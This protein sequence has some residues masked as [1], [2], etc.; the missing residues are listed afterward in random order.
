M[1]RL[2]LCF[3]AVVVM[4]ILYY[5]FSERLQDWRPLGYG[6]AGLYWALLLFGCAL[7]T[8]AAKKLRSA[9]ILAIILLL[10]LGSR[11]CYI[12]LIPTQPVSDFALL[13]ESAQAAAAGDF[14]WSQATSGYFYLWA[15]QIPFVLYEAGVLRLFHSLFALKF[16]NVLFM[17]GSNY[18]LYRIAKSFLSETAALCATL[19]YAAFPGAIMFASV[20]TNQHISLFFLL[21]GVFFLLQAESW[22]TLLLSGL[23]LAVS[24]LMRPEAIV[25]FAAMG[26]CGLL[27][28]IQH[29]TRKS[30]VSFFA[31]F[32]IVF[33]FYWVAQKLVEL[34]L[35]GM[36]VAPNGLANH[37]P[38]WKFVLGLGNVNGYGS[39]SGENIAI[40]SI[41]DSAAR[42]NAVI[43]VIRNAFAHSQISLKD[44]FLEKANR[45]WT[46]PQSMNWSTWN[47]ADN[48]QVLPGLT[49]EGF[50]AYM[51]WFE[52]AALLLV[53]LLALPAPVFL[54]RK[55][56]NKKG[57]ALFCLA[58][59]FI[60]FCVYLL[61]ETQI[62]Y[63]YFAIP[64]WILAGGI[65][66]EWLTGSQEKKE[67]TVK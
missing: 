2:A 16:L 37:A 40:L 67:R 56:N 58:I 53:Y 30:F 19:I 36:H 44:F 3:F 33:G 57:G 22:R 29:P 7:I 27:R 10:S 63:R 46:Q 61:I 26:C 9:S 54:W 38:E 62:R 17:V 39:Y 51:Q 24:N 28:W 20:L 49:V 55:E 18:L 35:M 42:K 1:E 52:R 34:A 32:A 11:L 23:S 31:G 14:S 4:T 47:L 48:A 64:F 21:L 45:F 41:A 25:I 8:L 66:L 50:R 60:T 6:M 13:Y 43:D 5:F 15:Y 59:L 12:L 65:T